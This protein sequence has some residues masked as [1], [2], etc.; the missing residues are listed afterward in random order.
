MSQITIN[1]YMEN[2]NVNVIENLLEITDGPLNNA[3]QQSAE[4]ASRSPMP[5]S[6]PTAH[7][8]T[9]R[10]PPGRMPGGLLDL[11]TPSPPGR[12]MR[13][14]NMEPTCSIC[15]EKICFIGR[16]ETLSCNHCFHK[17][18][19]RAWF[20]QCVGNDQ[21]KTCPV[22]RREFDDSCALQ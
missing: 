2:A 11:Y 3:L 19:I 13:L 8:D 12:V 21:P 17:E 1:V 9:P 4:E 22:C 7:N 20:A 14:R 18:C 5:R 10:S 15:Q 6:T 16:R